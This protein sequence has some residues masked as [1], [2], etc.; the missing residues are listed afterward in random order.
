MRTRLPLHSW[1]LTPREAIALQRE[2]A[3]RVLMDGA[4]PPERVRYVAGA[5]VAF[6][7]PGRRAVG[8]V[9][10]L[11]WPALDAV[12]QA[13]VEMPLTFPY[14]PGLLSFRESPVLLAAFDALRTAPDIVF[15]DGH[16]Y[17]HPRRFGIACHLGLLLD[18][19]TLGVAK[20]RLLG[21][22]GRIGVR[23]GATACLRDGDETIGTLV[24]T[25][26]HVRPVYVSIGHRMS[27]ADAEHW[28]L[29]CA[30]RYRLP[31]PAH[32][33][34]RRSA[35]CSK[36]RCPS[37]SS[38]AP[39]SAGAGSGSLRTT[40]SS[41]STTSSRCPSTTAAPSTSSIPATASC[42]T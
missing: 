7:K 31:E 25:R 21:T 11:S 24:R 27:L 37:S 42:S 9:I 6:D 39:A 2:L 18:V 10:V 29:A 35:A 16:G 15:V 38:S 20:S 3:P 30:R 5:D 32:S 33:R 19:A 36:R 8:A 28:A 13:T 14:V 26:D 4:P 40:R 17:A 41:T 23:R 12:D 34:A 22:H 1:D